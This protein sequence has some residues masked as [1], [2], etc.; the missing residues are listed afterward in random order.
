MLVLLLLAFVLLD[1]AFAFVK[2]QWARATKDKVDTHVTRACDFLLGCGE[3]S[4]HYVCSDYTR[5]VFLPAH[6]VVLIK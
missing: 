2:Y 3:A 6:G 4:L 1:Q 5:H